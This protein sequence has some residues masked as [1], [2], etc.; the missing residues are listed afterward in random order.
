MAQI[1]PTQPPRRG[2]PFPQRVLMA[3]LGLFAVFGAVRLWA[4]LQSWD[5][6]MAFGAQ[7]GPLY[8]ALSGAVTALGFLAALA[9]LVLRGRWSSRAVQIA[10]VVY[11]AWFWVDRLALHR[12]DST[13]NLPFLAGLSL[14]LLLFALAVARAY[15]PE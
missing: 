7:P 1:F 5:A 11:A 2:R 13:E 3:L 14:F 6:L 9:G 12:G 15:P 8:L 4:A 10:V